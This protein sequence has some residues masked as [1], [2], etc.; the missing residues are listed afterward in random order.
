MKT[1]RFILPFV[2]AVMLIFFSECSTAIAQKAKSIEPNTLIKL[3]G[4]TITSPSGDDW[5]YAKHKSHREV[6]LYN[7]SSNILTGSA[8]ST[9]ISVYKDSLITPADKEEKEYADAYLDKNVSD[10]K[11]AGLTGAKIKSTRK[12]DTTI[13]GRKFYAIAY[14]ASYRIENLQLYLDDVFFLYFPE[15]FKA[16][17]IFFGFNISCSYNQPLGILDINSSDLKPIFGIVKSF[18]TKEIVNPE[19]RN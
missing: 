6:Y 12:F 3:D 11:H 9:V 8:T 14:N 1:L 2:S 13:A 4:F 15:D 19:I 18:K 16:S 17:K 10:F 7:E 5:E